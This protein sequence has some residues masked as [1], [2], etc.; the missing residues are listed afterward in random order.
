MENKLSEY[1]YL[2]YFYWNVTHHAQILQK[3]Y[4]QKKFKLF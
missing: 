3:I 4:N 1:I 2:N